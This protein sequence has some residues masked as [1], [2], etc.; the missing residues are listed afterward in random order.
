MAGVKKKAV[1]LKIVLCIYYLLQFWK[2]S[3]DIEA[4]LDSKSEVNTMILIFTLK[5]SF[6]ICFTN[7]RAQKIVSSTLQTYKIV[8]ASF[9][10]E[11]KFRQARFF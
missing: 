7:V 6:K 11:D 1:L 9:Q 3:A 8:L 10:I 5:L 2:Y 4:L